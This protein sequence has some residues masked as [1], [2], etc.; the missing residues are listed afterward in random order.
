MRRLALL[1]TVVAFLGG[2][3]GVLAALQAANA[4]ADV[5]SSVVDHADQGQEAYFARHPNLQAENDVRMSLLSTRRALAAYQA[6][7]QAVSAGEAGDVSAARAAALKAYQ[8][9]R[10]LLDEVGILSGTA[11]GGVET[12][13][14][15]PGPLVLPTVKELEAER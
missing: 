15:D 3:S 6:A 4:A 1:V 2:C 14:P 7:S 9:L 10:A 12:E 5:L 13:A 11:E 8:E